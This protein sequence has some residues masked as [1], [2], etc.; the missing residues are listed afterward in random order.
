MPNYGERLEHALRLSK[1]DRMALSQVL[2]I[3]V[4]AIGQ[5]LA[6]KTK[7]LTA[8]NSA[9]AARFLGVDQ[10]W[11][12]TGEGRPDS[13]KELGSWPFSRLLH[14]DYEQLSD[15]Q[16]E[17][18]EDWLVQQVYAFLT[19]AQPKKIYRATGTG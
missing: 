1:R 17:A 13:H 12:A 9:R 8:E 11:L 19:P 6:G 16:K 10:F 5:V 15:A 2:G 4:Q 3:S 14:S 7:A 18:V